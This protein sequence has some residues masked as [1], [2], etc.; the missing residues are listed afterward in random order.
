M[1]QA[2]NK[3][4]WLVGWRP[5]NPRAEGWIWA[6][7]GA[8]AFSGKA[9]VAKLMYQLG[10]DPISTVGLRMLLALPLF[11]VM[12]WLSGRQLAADRPRAMPW[13]QLVALGFS[14]YY[15]ASTLDFMGL[16][17]ISASLERAIL[18]LN[19]TLVLAIGVWRHGQRLRPLQ[20]AALAVSY[21]GLTVVFWH[22]WRHVQL[23]AAGAD[24]EQ[25][26]FALVLGSLLVLGS[27]LAYAIYLVGSGQLVQTLGSQR[28]VS[29]ASC[30]ACA[31]CLAQWVAVHRLSGGAW[32]GVSQ[33]PW[34]AWGLSAIN[35]TVCTVVPIWMVMRGVQLIG[36][37]AA[38][39]V[40]MIGP[41]STLWMASV[42]LDEPVGPTLLLGTG[43]VL[44]GII[45]LGRLKPAA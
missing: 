43:L 25:A 6:A 9:I 45:W 17:Y 39:Q 22:D 29:W 37:S 38:S 15:L 35:A 36:A 31:M 8:V 1:V 41:L 5:A 34:Q 23:L 14:G 28:L 27:A 18:Y 11:A 19:P 40:G 32:G 26:T 44:A 7:L 16:R 10:A 20:L 30:F 21:L 13:G 3:S 2:M 33:L 12:A 42:L 24:P 4:T